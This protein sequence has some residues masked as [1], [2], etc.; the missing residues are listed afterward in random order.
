M[1]LTVYR[2][3]SHY[4]WLCHWPPFVLNIDRQKGGKVDH[5]NEGVL[6]EN[7]VFSQYIYIYIVNTMF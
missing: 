7:K 5:Q 3:F 1:Y 4:D 2:L 6:I